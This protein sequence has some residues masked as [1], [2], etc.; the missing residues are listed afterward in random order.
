MSSEKG[1]TLVELM[2]SVSLLAVAVAALLTTIATVQRSNLLCEEE[3]LALDAALAKME[4]IR[5]QAFGDIEDLYDSNPTNDPA[6]AGVG[7]WQFFDPRT[8][9]TRSYEG[10]TFAGDP[11]DPNDP[12]TAPLVRVFRAG[13]PMYAIEPPLNPTG[14]S[15]IPHGEVIVVAPQHFSPQPGPDEN[16]YYPDPA[17][18]TYPFP[19]T[20]LPVD[21]NGRDLPS[22]GNARNDNPATLEVGL[23]ANGILVVVI[24]RWRSVATR[25]NREVVLRTVV[26]DR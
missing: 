5:E 16:S 15:C 14:S 18:P 13:R 8:N 24:V 20:D 4:E 17:Y 7:T 6:G 25:T 9:G 11:N 2:M 3:A 21:L 19:R 23:G 12:T 1:L 22:D 10:S 26:A